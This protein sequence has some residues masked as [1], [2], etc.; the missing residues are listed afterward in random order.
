M[1]LSEGLA[2][3]ALAEL[4]ISVQCLGN[5]LEQTAALLKNL[6]SDQP[7]SEDAECNGI[8]GAA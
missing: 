8:A 3:A 4:V 2:F 6:D 5:D 7:T 1:D